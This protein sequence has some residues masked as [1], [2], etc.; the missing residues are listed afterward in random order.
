M[1]E[2]TAAGRPAGGMGGTDCPESGGSSPA[3]KRRETEKKKQ[4]P[5]GCVTQQCRG[6]TTS[7]CFCH[8]FSQQR[9]E[10]Y[11]MKYSN[12]QLTSQ[13]KGFDDLH[14]STRGA[15][16]IFSPPGSTH[17]WC[18]CH[19]SQN[20]TGGTASQSGLSLWPVGSGLSEG[21]PHTQ[22]WIRHL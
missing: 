1:D 15:V 20:R 9:H 14:L 2:E 6:L 22:R 10:E 17:C 21:R 16:C 4:W 11:V 19:S 13:I 3:G 7:I 18:I 5:S 12:V 8:H